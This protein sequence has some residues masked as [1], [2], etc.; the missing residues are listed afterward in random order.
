MDFNLIQGPGKDP[1]IDAIIK[2]LKDKLVYLE[3]PVCRENMKE[4]ERRAEV[5]R[6]TELFRSALAVKQ[7]AGIDPLYA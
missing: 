3:T 6:I 1:Y 7:A 2:T 5:K 4:E